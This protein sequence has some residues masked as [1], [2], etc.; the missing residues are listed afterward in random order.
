MRFVHSDRTNDIIVSSLPGSTAVC[1]HGNQHFSQDERRIK[2]FA[3][4][5][6]QTMCSH[7]DAPPGV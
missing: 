1:D 6:R 4:G 5:G 7:N 3:T 2:S